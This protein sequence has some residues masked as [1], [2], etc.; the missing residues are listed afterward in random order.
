M[1]NWLNEN[2]GL[3]MAI[4]TL[5]YVIATLFILRAN[6]KT[7]K[8]SQKQLTEMQNQSFELNRGVLIARFQEID[9]NFILSFENIGKSIIQDAIIKISKDFLDVFETDEQL[10][11]KNLLISST[12][13]KHYFA[14]NQILNYFIYQLLSHNALYE[15][16]KK[17]T[18]EF[19]FEYTTLGRRINEK[20]VIN[21]NPILASFYGLKFEEI[22]NEKI[23]NSI[24]EITKELRTQNNIILKTSQKIEKMQNKP[25]ITNKNNSDSVDRK[26]PET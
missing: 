2:S 22:L 18:V 23:T 21:L 4:L 19:G 12:N 1:I 14:P 24:E 8:I 11:I 3:I 16:L 7:T 10:Y 25:K 26:F 5:V 17:T 20:Y 13:Q 15:R 6:N 9:K